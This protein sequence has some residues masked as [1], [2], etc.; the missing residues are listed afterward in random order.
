M[1]TR[2]LIVFENLPPLAPSLLKKVCRIST[3]VLPPQPPF[4]AIFASW[5]TFSSDRR[6]AKGC[7]YLTRKGRK[8]VFGVDFLL[9]SGF[10]V[11]LFCSLSLFQV[12]Q[13]MPKMG[14]E[15]A[16]AILNSPVLGGCRWMN[17]C[18]LVIWRWPLF[19]WLWPIFRDLRHR[20]YWVG[21][22]STPLPLLKM[23]KSKT[24]GI[25]ASEEE[26]S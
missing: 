22:V 4:F 12:G 8:W 23:K 1:S 2:W 11:L 24:M 15:W 26:G 18:E 6:G 7:E 5:V 10:W 21:G 25:W 13:T 14:D 3:F 20:Q 16:K 9:C 19:R 17:G